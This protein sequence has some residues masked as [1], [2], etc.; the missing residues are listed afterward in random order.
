MTLSGQG[1]TIKTNPEL[2]RAQRICRCLNKAIRNHQISRSP[3]DYE[4]LKHWQKL[5][6]NF[7]EVTNDQ[8]DTY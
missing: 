7:Y 2:L 3:K 8:L 1:K 5:T 6:L 4:R